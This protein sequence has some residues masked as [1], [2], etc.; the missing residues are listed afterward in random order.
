MSEPLKLTE[1]EPRSSGHGEPTDFVQDYLIVPT[2]GI[3]PSRRIFHPDNDPW[4]HS[5]REDHSLIL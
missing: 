5:A 3:K 2:T 4:W 1:W